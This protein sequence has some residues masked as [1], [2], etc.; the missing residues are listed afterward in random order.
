MKRKDALNLIRAEYAKHGKA[1]PASMRMYVESR[2]SYAAYNEAAK[3]G[4][5]IFAAGKQ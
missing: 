4:M 5:K 2:I 3:A 1:T